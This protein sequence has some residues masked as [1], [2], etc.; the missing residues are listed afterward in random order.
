M[1]FAIFATLFTSFPYREKALTS[2]IAILRIND[3]L[4]NN[5][6]EEATK[7]NG[8]AIIQG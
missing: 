6:S 5:Y 3:F 4:C 7:L 1:S 2:F 8:I